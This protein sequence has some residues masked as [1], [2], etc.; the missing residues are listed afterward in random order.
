MEVGTKRR[1]IF[2]TEYVK[3]GDAETAAM[4]AGFSINTLSNTAYRLM[5]IYGVRQRILEMGGTLPPEDEYRELPVKTRKDVFTQWMRVATFDPRRV[6]DEHGNQI[7]IHRLDHE[8]ASCI[9]SFETKTDREGN[10]TLAV[11]FYD[12]LSALNSVARSLGMFQDNMHITGEV[13]LEKM[14]DDELQ[15]LVREQMKL[16]RES[17]VNIQIDNG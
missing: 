12:R 8:V 9:Q 17:G 2:C 10:V 5:S 1:E 15:N 6:L 11:K 14:S 16:L 13:K 7:P 4:M 3:T